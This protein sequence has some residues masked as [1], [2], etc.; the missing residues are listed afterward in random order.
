[1]VNLF[2]NNKGRTPMPSFVSSI[3]ANTTTVSFLIMYWYRCNNRQCKKRVSFKKKISEYANGKVCAD[4]GSNL[5]DASYD[6][7][8]K[9]NETCT[10]DAYHFPH[11]KGSSV[12]CVHSKKQ[13]SEEDYENMYGPSGK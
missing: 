10:C 9:R 5:H 8:H 11:R 2:E 12:F 13:P 1:M 7:K 4:C 3:I 6:K